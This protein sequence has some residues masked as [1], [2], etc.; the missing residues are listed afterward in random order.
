MLTIYCEETN[1]NTLL[2]KYIN[3]NT[4][5]ICNG[6]KYKKIKF[7]LVKGTNKLMSSR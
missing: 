7:L 1:I 3:S 4:I 2:I 6:I 5:K